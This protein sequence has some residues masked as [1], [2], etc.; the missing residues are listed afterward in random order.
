M[1]ST[2]DKNTITERSTHEVFKDVSLSLCNHCRKMLF[3]EQKNISNTEDFFESLGGLDNSSAREKE[4]DLFGY[5]KEWPK[6]SEKYR[7][8]QNYT[9]ENCNVV[10]EGFNKWYLEVHHIDGNKMNNNIT[11]LKC[12]CIKCHSQI[13]ERHKEN[14]SARFNQKRLAAFEKLFK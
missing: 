11:N 12:L 7:E 4:V 14:Y 6:I 13:N 9:C 8:K 10:L 3:D 5:I 1:F 2:A